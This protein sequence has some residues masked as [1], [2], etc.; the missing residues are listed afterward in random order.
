MINNIVPSATWTQYIYKFHQGMIILWF[1]S[2]TCTYSRTKKGISKF[3]TWDIYYYNKKF[4][5]KKKDLKNLMKEL[6]L[7]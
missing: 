1:S 7:C 4:F 5:K 2:A 3:E 6:T